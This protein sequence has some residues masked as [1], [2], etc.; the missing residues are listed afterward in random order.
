MRANQSLVR[1]LGSHSGKVLSLVFSS[2]GLTLATGGADG[3][4]RLWNVQAALAAA[5]RKTP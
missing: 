1:R 4:A 5:P 3:A 2:D